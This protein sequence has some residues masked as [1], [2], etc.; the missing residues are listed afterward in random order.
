MRSVSLGEYPLCAACQL[1]NGGLTHTRHPQIHVEA[2]GRSACV[3]E[4]LA[5]IFSDIWAFAETCGSCQDLDGRAYIT[6]RPTHIP[7]VIDYLAAKGYAPVLEERLYF[8]L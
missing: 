4:R 5:G 2:Y 3:D 1:S 7:L 8:T 6:V